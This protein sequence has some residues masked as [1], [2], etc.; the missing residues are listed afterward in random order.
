MSEKVFF[1]ED[2]VTGKFVVFFE[3]KKEGKKLADEFFK[4]CDGRVP[5]A[6]R[7]VTNTG[8]HGVA[9][10]EKGNHVQSNLWLEAGEIGLGT[11]VRF[12]N[13]LVAKP[14]IGQ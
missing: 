12:N 7:I 1:G 11:P 6:Q 5:G 9:S 14:L 8:E 3:G 2:I 10:N 4:F 13:N